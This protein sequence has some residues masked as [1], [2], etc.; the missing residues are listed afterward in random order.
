MTTNAVLP[1]PV[2]G[3][4]I[5]RIY[6]QVEA[7]LNKWDR[8]G[9]CPHCVARTLLSLAGFFAAHE[10]PADSMR[11]MLGHIA[12]LSEKYA[13]PSDRAGLH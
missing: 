3:D 6:R 12:E 8:R 1:K 13:P 2:L 11:E 10:L 9:Y 7:I 4:D 5:D